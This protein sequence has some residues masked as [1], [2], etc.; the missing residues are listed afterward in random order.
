MP[1]MEW[2]MVWHSPTRL[3]R[4]GTYKIYARDTFEALIQSIWTSDE[5]I[6]DNLSFG[7]TIN[8]F[9]KK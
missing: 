6:M 7:G 8:I 4:V 2:N 5:K 1:Q 3:E 9:L